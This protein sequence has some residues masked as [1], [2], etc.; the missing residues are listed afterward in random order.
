MDGWMDG[1][2]NE[3]GTDA[4][5]LAPSSTLAFLEATAVSV[6]LL[7]GNVSTTKS[8]DSWWDFAHSP[9]EHFA[10]FRMT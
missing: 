4:L 1:M 6:I 9:C 5:N 10:A 3:C 2:L 8:S 7:L